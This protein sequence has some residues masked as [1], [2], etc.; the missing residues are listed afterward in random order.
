VLGTVDPTTLAVTGESH[1]AEM[2]HECRRNRR[3]IDGAWMDWIVVRNRLAPL[4]FRNNRLI[5][6]CLH[7]LGGYR[8]TE[9][10]G[11]GRL[12]RVVSRGLTGLIAST[13][14]SPARGP[15]SRI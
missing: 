11:E 10:F 4:G 7:R 1:Y 2:V 12:P 9:G 13:S 3:S 6:E 5:G 8:S 15:I 14:I